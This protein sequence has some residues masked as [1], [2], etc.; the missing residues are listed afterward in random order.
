MK[1]FKS[2]IL[3][4]HE[5]SEEWQEEAIS[6]LDEFAQEASYL[7]PDES[8][9][10]VEHVLMDLNEAWRAE[11]AHENGFEYNATIGISNNSAMLLNIS[12]CG[13]QATY[14]YV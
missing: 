2:N 13:T 11:G 9:N 5:L 6:N 4:F 8:H 10:P 12:E 7:E 14:I 3:N 1:I